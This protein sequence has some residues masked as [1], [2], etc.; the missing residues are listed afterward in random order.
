MTTTWCLLRVLVVQYLCTKAKAHGQH[1]QEG[2][3]GWR[4]S[5][6]RGSA[7]ACVCEQ[8]SARRDA[9]AHATRAKARAASACEKCSYEKRFAHL[10]VKKYDWRSG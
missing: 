4:R 6:L 5:A 10:V 2:G 3:A 1:H 9:A 7:S 8:G